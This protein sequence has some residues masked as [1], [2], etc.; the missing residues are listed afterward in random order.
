MPYLPVIL[1]GLLA[2]INLFVFAFLLWLTCKFCR[3]RRFSPT[4]DAPPRIGIRFRRAL[5]VVVVLSLC[6]MLGFLALWLVPPH[7]VELELRW[8]IAALAVHI[9]LL[10]VV[11]RLLVCPTMGRTILVALL[12]EILG[13]LYTVGFVFAVG[14]MLLSGYVIP[15]GNMAET[16][17]GYH[18]DVSC[19]TCGHEFAINCSGEGDP[20]EGRPMPTFAC[21]CPNCRQR[22]H[23]PNAPA[24]FETANPDSVRI[25]EP[26]LQRG[27]RFLAGR[28]LLGADRIVPQRFEVVVFEYPF[29]RSFTYIKRLIGL[30]G[31]TIAIR[32][33]DVYVLGEDKGIKYDAAEAE[34]EVKVEYEAKALLHP[35]DPDAIRRFEEGQFEILRK[36]PEHILTLRRLVYDNDHPAKGQPPRWKGEDGW[37]ADGNGFRSVSTTE[38]IA[39]LRYR[40]LLPDSQD[41]PALITDFSGYDAY[42]NAH[43]PPLMDNNWVGDL[44]LECEAVLDNPQGELTLELSHGVDRFQARWDLSTGSC[45]LFRVTEDGEQKLDTKPTALNKKGSYHLRFANVDRRLVVWVD[46]DLPFDNGVSYAAPAALGPHEQNDLKKP[47]SIGVRG[48]AVAVQKIKLFRDTYYTVGGVSHGSPHEPDAHGFEAAVPDTWRDLKNPPFVTM[49]V[50]PEHYFMLG[51]NS[52]ESADSRSWGSVPHRLLLGRAFFVYYPWKRVGPLH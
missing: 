18:K 4:A 11:V 12:Y 38:R 15:T 23:F 25:A 6:G 7:Q 20:S 17:L 52:S 1:L 51:D 29:R 13:T 37:N 3:V 47:A 50:Q 9:V 42:Q 34:Q 19:P 33:G 44:I 36:E 8:S 32:G 41:K 27:D 26:A 39:W 35:D 49:Y 24:S 45:T 16:L 40:H 31:E 28:G 2:L 5:G 48:A 46:G 43:H 30:P 21:V 22:I 14:S 10:L